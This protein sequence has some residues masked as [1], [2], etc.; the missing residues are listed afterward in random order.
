ML[1]DFIIFKSSCR[2]IPAQDK[3]TLF[4]VRSKHCD[5]RQSAIS[6]CGNIMSADRVQYPIA[7]ALWRPTEYS[8]RLE[9][10][11]CR[12]TECSIRLEQALCRPTECSIRLEQ[13]SWRPTECSIR[14][15]KALWR[16]TECLI[17]LEKAFCRASEYSIQMRKHYDGRQSVISN[18][19]S[20]LSA[21]RVLTSGR[22]CLCRKWT[23]Q[24]TLKM[25]GL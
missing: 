25:S 3:E 10:A 21:V 23:W 2:W 20:I 13:A 1:C 19:G 7:E 15:E 16:P 5:G 6:D 14:L 9:Q 12:P 22:D 17:P 8:I 24:M 18:R 11:L 4:S